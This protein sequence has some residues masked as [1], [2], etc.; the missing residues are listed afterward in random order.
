[1]RLTLDADGEIT[2][3]ERILTEIGH[4][5]RDVAEGPDGRIYILTESGAMAAPGAIL[6]LTQN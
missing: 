4:R 6:V 3:E 5:F 1:V 2:G